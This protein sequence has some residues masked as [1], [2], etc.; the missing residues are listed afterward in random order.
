FGDQLS[1]VAIEEL[2]QKLKPSDVEGLGEFSLFQ[3][4][5]RVFAHSEDFQSLLD[6]YDIEEGDKF[7]EL[8]RG[9][10]SN[11]W[12]VGLLKLMALAKENT[13]KEAVVELYKYTTIDKDMSLSWMALK[14]LLIK[15]LIDLKRQSIN[16]I[17]EQLTGR[18]YNDLPHEIGYIEGLI[19]GV[20]GLRHA[21]KAP[22]FDFS[23]KQSAV[24]SKSLREILDLF[25]QNFTVD[26]IVNHVKEM[27]DQHKLS[28]IHP[29]TG[30]NIIWEM[31]GIAAKDQLIAAGIDAKNINDLLYDDAGVKQL[32]L[33]LLLVKL[34]ILQE[35]GEDG[36]LVVSNNMIID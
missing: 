13:L 27:L 15:E 24:T 30:V 20:I 14:K 16:A 7:R 17:A 32:A 25:H 10:V 6:N 26:K 34:G 31:V 8:I 23:M 4:E 22:N 21:H 2:I 36:H 28:I 35:V 12:S 11:G 5:M 1:S 33:P 3:E 19:G 9:Y 29:E 18:T